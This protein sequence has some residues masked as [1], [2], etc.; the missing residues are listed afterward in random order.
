MSYLKSQSTIEAGGQSPIRLPS[1]S[2]WP[3]PAR[4]AQAVRMKR[5]KAGLSV[6]ILFHLFCILLAPNSDN[7][8]GFR[9]GKLIQPYV[10]FLELTNNWNFFAPNPEPPIYVEYELVDPD[11][12]GYK[13]GMWPEEKDPFF[14]RDRQ[15]RRI[16]SA[17]FMVNTEMHAEKMMVPYL[18]NLTPRPH[19]IRL[20]RVMRTVPSPQ[21]VES[22]KRQ[23]G[24]RV[25]ED[26][27]F[28][29]HT[30]CDAGGGV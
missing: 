29:S 3:S 14:L 5:V 6:F 27:K 19:S 11:G 15:T 26:R 4:K 23:I 16:S 25:G 1:F 18:C 21:D 17:D 13:Q 10:F 20:W 8:T 22:G 7:Y 12:Q 28:V 24:D 30:F 9:F 2:E